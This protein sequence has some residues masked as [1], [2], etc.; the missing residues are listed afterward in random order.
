MVDAA[1]VESGTVTESAPAPAPAPSVQDAMQK[2]LETVQENKTQKAADKLSGAET[3]APNK[4]KTTPQSTETGEVDEAAAKR[5]EAAKKG[6]ET[7]RKNAEAAKEAE[8]AESAKASEERVK[9]AEARAAKAEKAAEKAAK[10]AE[11]DAT[12][13]AEAEASAESD[14]QDSAQTGFKPPA[15]WSADA[16]ADWEATPETV[17]GQV[18]RTISE[19][20]QGLEKHKGNSEKWE[21]VA[22]FEPLA[23]QFN[24]DLPTVLSDYN[25]MSKMMRTNPIQGI[26]YLAERHGIGLTQLAEQV[27]GAQSSEAYKAMESNLIKTQNA[28]KAAQSK[29]Q[30]YHQAEL[31]E[32]ANYL[33]QVRLKNPDF[34]ELE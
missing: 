6:A 28:L 29:L 7:K 19:M 20:Q 4:A 31:R 13:E 1:V 17:R 15:E 27:L 10:A 24:A 14:T 5:S 8:A 3:D 25:E 18:E 32:N 26:Q 34:A 16:K 11:T 9:D 2:A 21:S 33:D 12:S 30:G 22:Q 23:K